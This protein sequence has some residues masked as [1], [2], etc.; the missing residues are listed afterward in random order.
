[1]QFTGMKQVKEL[2]LIEY[3]SMDNNFSRSYAAGFA[4]V[5]FIIW[6]LISETKVL[7]LLRL[8]LLKDCC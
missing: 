8:I 5:D 6:N 2:S 3:A 1:M 4:S 7:F